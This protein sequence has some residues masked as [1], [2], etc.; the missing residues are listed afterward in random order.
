MQKVVFD[1]SSGM[2]DDHAN[3]RGQG[4]RHENGD[5][6]FRLDEQ[7]TKM[8]GDFELLDAQPK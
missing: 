8:G 6:P 5:Q 3:D 4:D 1:V 7:I 2:D